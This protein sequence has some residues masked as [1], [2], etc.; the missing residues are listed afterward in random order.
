MNYTASS[1]KKEIESKKSLTVNGDLQCPQSSD[2][3]ES[4]NTLCDH[5]SHALCPHAKTQM[6]KQKIHIYEQGAKQGA[7]LTILTFYF[8]VSQENPN[9]FID[10]HDQQ[11]CRLIRRG[12]SSGKYSI[13]TMQF[14]TV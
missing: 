9:G 4:G 2:W 11:L 5:E 6:C 13:D 1:V 7:P 8:M 3:I 14:D 12:K 10:A